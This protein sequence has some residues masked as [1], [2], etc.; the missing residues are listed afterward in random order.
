MDTKD[1]AAID[2]FNQAAD[3]RFLEQTASREGADFER[4]KPF[5]NLETAAPVLYKFAL[6]LAALDLREGMKVLDFGS[7]P[8]WVA[9]C[10]NYMGVE[11]TGV[12]I[13]PACAEF[14]RNVAR[15]D[16]YLRPDVP[17]HYVTYDG[18]SFPF[19]DGAFDRV[20]CFDAFHHIPNKRQIMAEFARV[21]VEGGKV[22]LVEPGPHHHESDVAKQ[23]LAQGVLEDSVSLNEVIELAAACGLGGATIKPYPPE[24]RLRFD[25]AAFKA[26]MGG[27]D[28]PF[29]LNAVRTDLKYAFIATLVR[30]APPDGGWRRPWWRFWD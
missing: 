20:A 1:V 19:A 13:S 6:M 25:A 3:R 2:R 29:K 24:N 17:L 23:E 8:G 12:E 15:S 27:D 22:A 14:A 21:L 26:F 11:A 7:G 10:L 16:P 5:G 28:R 18:Y 9:R 4:R 30:G